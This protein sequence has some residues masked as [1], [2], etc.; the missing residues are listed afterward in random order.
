[1]V[2]PPA[3]R[4]AA[5]KF[6][7]FGRLGWQVS[8]LGFGAWPLGGGWG[9]QSDVDSLSALARFMELGG[10][11]IDT[12]QVYGDGRSEQ[13]IASALQRR[14][15][16]DPIYVATKIPPAPGL[17]PP[18]PYDRIEDRYGA[19]YLQQRLERSLRALRTDCIDLV[20]LHT[21]T[22]A[23]NRNPLALEVLEKFRREGKL[24]AI[25]ISTPEHDQNSLVELMRL[26]RLDAVQLIYNIFDQEPQAELLPTAAQHA[27]A[28]IVRVALDEGALTEKF[29][30]HTR[31]AD[32]DFRLQYFAGDRVERT[33][34]RVA[35]IR[36]AIAGEEPDLAVAALKFALKPEAV[37]VV[38]PGM[39]NPAQVQANLA[40][41]ALP[42]LADSVEQRLRQHQWRRGDWY[43]GK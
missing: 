1:M 3:Q 32:G 2:V 31:F 43:K 20:Q 28:V 11:F 39:R 35:R 42:P 29:G 18:S 24:R 34:G 8:E 21:W 12:A 25:G 36:E 14:S 7:R 38:I 26:G 37:S 40:V 4:F 23:W 10:N 16:A 33:A 27:V 15:G 13:L 19:A 30:T 22:R 5:V 6:R 41:S 17:W 9:A